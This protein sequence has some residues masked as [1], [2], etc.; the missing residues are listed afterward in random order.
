MQKIVLTPIIGSQLSE[1][2]AK[3]LVD[4]DY[5]IFNKE[6]GLDEALRYAVGQPMGALS[7]WAMLALTHH[8]LVQFAY[9]RSVN[10]PLT[11]HRGIGGSKGWKPFQGYSI[12]GD[13]VV[14]NDRR[15]APQYVR[16]MR[17]IGVGI[18]FA[19]EVFGF[20]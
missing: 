2:W 18:G 6:F 20:L 3:L 1:L 5:R 14:I 7:S 8:M 16:L 10:K 19:Q 17:E 12:L 11:I 15:V 9:F 13:D 4:R